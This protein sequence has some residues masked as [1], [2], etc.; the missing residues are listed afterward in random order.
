MTKDAVRA[1][2]YSRDFVISRAVLR[3]YVPVSV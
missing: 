2:V 1:Y 3:D